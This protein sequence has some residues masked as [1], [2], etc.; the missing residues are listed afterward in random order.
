M[1]RRDMLKLMLASASVL[2]TPF[3]NLTRAYAYATP[4]ASDTKFLLVLLRGAYDATNV[5]IPVSSSF[6]YESRPTLA[7]KKPNIN[8]PQ[9]ALALARAGKAVEWGLHPALKD[10]LFPLWQLGQV[11]FIPFAGTN[12]QSRSHF[13]AQDSLEEGLF[14]K[15]QGEYSSGFL[16]RLA[17]VLGNTAAPV[18]FTDGL[19]LVMS[20]DLVVPNVSLKGPG[21]APFDDRQATLLADMYAGTR[22]ESLVNEGFEL[23]QTVAEQAAM[24]QSE[25]RN[26][27]SAHGFELEAQRMAGLMRDKFNLGFI[28]IG[29]WDTHVNQGGMQ[30]QLAN[31]LANLGTG[32]A[33]F[34]QQMGTAWK[35]TVVVVLS[36]FGRTFRENGTRGT[37]HGHGTAYWVLGGN[38]HG[39]RIVGEQVRVERKTLNQD[40]DWPVLTE[41]RTLLGGLFQKMYG[42]DTAQLNRI[43]PGAT[44]R[45]LGLV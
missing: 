13:E 22:L 40:R 27:I 17:N 45:N 18:A 26:A 12:D 38:V 32:L 28:D 14:G 5:I 37:D 21:H 10:T 9:S 34:A 3:S 41:Y 4:G 35:N 29:G 33:A 44:P 20:G 42:L 6:Y 2:A 15:K 7:I 1:Q 30:G 19:P 16:N 11:A 39:G 24:M 31:L 25:N 36:E 43:F 23:R 8:D